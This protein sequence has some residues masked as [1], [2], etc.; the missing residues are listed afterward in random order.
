MDYLTVIT[1]LK[2]PLARITGATNA[3]TSDFKAES[4]TLERMPP[5]TQPAK[6]ATLESERGGLL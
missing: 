4:A 6:A 2:A 5:A 3:A 1:D